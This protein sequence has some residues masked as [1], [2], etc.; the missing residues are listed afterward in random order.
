MR[1]FVTSFLAPERNPEI[2]NFALRSP[3]EQRGE[4]IHAARKHSYHEREAPHQET[5]K[6]NPEKNSAR[7]GAEIL[8]PPVLHQGGA[9]SWERWCLQQRVTNVISENLERFCS[10]SSRNYRPAKHEPQPPLSRKGW[11][12]FPAIIQK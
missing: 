9:G 2:P 5:W 3:I 10:N 1:P 4:S 8:R 12:W 11:S 6:M 7:E